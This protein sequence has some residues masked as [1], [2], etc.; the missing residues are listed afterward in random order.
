MPPGIA[1]K[2]FKA[3]GMTARRVEG[4]VGEALWSGRDGL[5][6]SRCHSRAHVL[7]RHLG[8][9][10]RMTGSPAPGV[11]PGVRHAVH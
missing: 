2:A 8:D 3:A 4:D 11:F 9:T 10:S 6:R 7:P 5:E 1:M